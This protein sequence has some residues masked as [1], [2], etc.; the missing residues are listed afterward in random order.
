MEKNVAD[1][2]YLTRKQIESYEKHRIT[3][4]EKGNG[5]GGVPI[6]PEREK[7]CHTILTHPDKSSGN[8][9]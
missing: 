6:N 5:F 1:S 3:Q 4:R 9:I 2:F 8:M 7:I